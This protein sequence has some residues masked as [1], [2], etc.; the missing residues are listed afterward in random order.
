LHFFRPRRFSRAIETALK[1][2]PGRVAS[3][4][5]YGLRGV[6]KTLLAAA[7]ADGHRGDYRATWWIRAQTNSTMRADFVALGIRLGWVEAND[8]EESAV[9]VVME[10]LRHEGE[11]ILLIYDNAIDAEALKP[12][13]PISGATRVLITSNARDWRSV[14]DPI[15]IRVWPTNI[16]AAFL[17]ARIGR[18]GERS[19]A[20]AVSE[21]LGGLPLAHEQ[22]AAYGDRLEVSFAEYGHRFE[23]APTRLLGDARYAPADYHDRLTVAKTFKLAID[24]AAKLHAGAEPLIVHAALL[25]PEPIPLFLFAEGREQFGE[26]LKSALADDGL[27][28]AL[29][30]LLVRSACASAISGNSGVGE[31]PLSADAST[32]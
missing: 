12:Y 20:E 27:D 8:K 24:E 3:T 21:M 7:Y 18:A 16:G 5:L 28:E 31:K 14:A 13:L 22:A 26:P 6:G 25:A 23:K 15:E 30:E 11:G 32:A 4:A 10:R 2:K 17:I 1:S 9:A 29:A 19:A